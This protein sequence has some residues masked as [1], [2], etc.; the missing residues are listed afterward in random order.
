MLQPRA[1]KPARHFWDILILLWHNRWAYI[2]QKFPN[3][4]LLF[5]GLS[6][7]IFLSIQG[8]GR[9]DR[10]SV[11]ECVSCYLLSFQMTQHDSTSP[12]GAGAGGSP[13][14]SIQYECKRRN[15]FNAVSSSPGSHSCWTTSPG[16]L[17]EMNMFMHRAL[18]S[19]KPFR[20]AANCMAC[21]GQD[22]FSSSLENSL[23]LKSI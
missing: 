17:T 15:F 6:L 10:P 7:S 14:S 8:N 3:L 19:P 18:L 20:Y 23:V 21:S 5:S 1:M 12:G 22:S 16:L 2:Y 4:F 13:L 11:Y 9:F